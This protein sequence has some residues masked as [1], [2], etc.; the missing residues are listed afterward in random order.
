MRL[1]VLLL[2]ATAACLDARPFH[3]PW[4][5]R[6]TQQAEARVFHWPWNSRAKEQQRLN[7]AMA[8]KPTSREEEILRPD[9]TKE[10]NLGSAKFGSGRAVSGGKTTGGTF[11]FESKTQ[12]KNFPTS[13]V[14]PQQAWGTDSK[15]ATKSAETKESWFARLTARAKTYETRENSDAN[16]GL[17]GSTLPGSDKRFAVRGR[18]QAELDTDRVEGRAPK[19]PLGGD[20]DGGQSWNGELKPLTVQDVKTLLNKN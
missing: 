11:Q 9:V 16:K 5:T 20:R 18:R 19:M 13:T 6:T 14:T 10:F 1:P 15:Y 8:P 7:A 3:W 17:Q 4:S 2:L 12:T